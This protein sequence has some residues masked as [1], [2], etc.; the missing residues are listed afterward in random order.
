MPLAA[1]LRLRADTRYAKGQEAE[2]V[3]ALQDAPGPVLVAW[4]YDHIGAIIAHL[5]PVDPTPPAWPSDCFDMVYVFSR[6]G[7]G[8]IFA[9][10][11]QMLL[12]GDS[13]TPIT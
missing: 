9:Q 4:E 2:L 3:S 8:W 5:G 7:N 1:A 11:P 10:I 12:A 13:P 6:N